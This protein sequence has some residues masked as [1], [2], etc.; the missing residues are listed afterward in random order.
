MKYIVMIL[1]L[2]MCLCFVYKTL[3]A[4]AVN[5]SRISRDEEYQEFLKKAKTES[6]PYEDS[7]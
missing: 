5:A 3:I 2:M 6:I 1:T 7:A 4:L